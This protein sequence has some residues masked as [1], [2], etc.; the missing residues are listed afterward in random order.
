MGSSFLSA[1]EESRRSEFGLPRSQI[2]MRFWKQRG[3][4]QSS[5]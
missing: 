1:G 4:H 5:E 3:L 2:W